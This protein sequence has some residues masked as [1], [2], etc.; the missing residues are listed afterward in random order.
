MNEKQNEEQKL[1][2]NENPNKIKNEMKKNRKTK[3]N[4]NKKQF[5][6]WG[7]NLALLYV[8]VQRPALFGNDNSNTVN[9]WH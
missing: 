8:T 2:N 3:K 9:R 6:V 1:K 5:L 7:S 4:K